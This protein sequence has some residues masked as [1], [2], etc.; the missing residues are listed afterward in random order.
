[1]QTLNDCSSTLRAG[2]RLTHHHG[3][4]TYDYQKK[5]HASCFLILKQP[6]NLHRIYTSKSSLLADGWSIMPKNSYIPNSSLVCN[7]EIES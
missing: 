3:C 4:G 7:G 2:E 6:N 5:Q 1:M